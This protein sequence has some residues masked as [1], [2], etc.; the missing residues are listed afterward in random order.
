MNTF[1]FWSTWAT[2]TNRPGS[3]ITYTNNWPNEDLIDNKP[4]GE[5]VVWSVVS[6]VMLLAGVGALAW[7]FAVQRRKEPHIEEVYPEKDPLLALSATPSMKAT[8]KYFWVV[9]ALFV[10]QIA[11][12][13]LYSS[14]R[15]GGLGILWYSYSGMDPVF[16][17]SNMAYTVRYFVDCNSM[18]SNRIIYGSCSIRV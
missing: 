15:G 11:F 4:T 17:C 3:D 12:G 5:M 16:R 13:V 9:T 18:A 1:F 10:V 7:Y 8:L 2:A 14:L 6:F